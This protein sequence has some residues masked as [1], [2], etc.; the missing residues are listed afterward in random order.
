MPTTH[1]GRVLILLPKRDFDPSEAAVTWLILAGSGLSVTFATPDG[2]PADAD[3]LMLSGEGLDLWGKVPLLRKLKCLGLLL[4]ANAGARR[5]YMQM[6]NSAAF[7]EPAKYSSLTVS[8]YDG[9]VLPGG[10]W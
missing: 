10:H 3:P 1:P 4:R 5:A 9:L 2:Q 6:Q 7:L 8:D